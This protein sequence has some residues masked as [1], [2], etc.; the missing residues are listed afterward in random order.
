[1]RI[2]IF[3]CGYVGLVTG[4]CFAEVGHQ[5]CCTDKEKATIEALCR[6]ELPIYEPGLD[7]LV[8]RNVLAGRLS[9]TGNLGDAVR[10]AD[11]I[12]ICVGTPPLPN[13]DAD[14]SGLDSVARTI[15]LEAHGSKLV[16]EKSTVP[17][18]TGDM[19]TRALEIGR[20]HV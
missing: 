6:G 20:A 13:G 9:F 11:T 4:A 18:R 3:G 10:F 8:R 17:M 7:L 2:S 1:M 12:F 15:G 5:V 16:V 19:L 14:V